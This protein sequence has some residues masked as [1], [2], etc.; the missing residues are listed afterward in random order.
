VE[1]G[2]GWYPVPGPEFDERLALLNR[3]CE[4]RGRD[5]SEIDVCL[6]TTVDSPDALAEIKDKGI[7]RVVLGLPTVA[8]DEALAVMDGYASIIEWANDLAD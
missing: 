7:N 6:L 5:R 1:Y 2:D 4:E 3:L 8:E